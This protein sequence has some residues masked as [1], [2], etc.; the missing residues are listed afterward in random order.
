MWH[1][2]DFPAERQLCSLALV[3]I[4][5]HMLQQQGGGERERTPTPQPPCV[6]R[7]SHTDS[8]TLAVLPLHFP[9]QL[10]QANAPT[11]PKSPLSWSFA[12]VG[13]KVYIL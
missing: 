10:E 7:L 3:H 5:C 11:E 8:Q 6:T 12:L 1:R 2:F 9:L 13:I 4:F